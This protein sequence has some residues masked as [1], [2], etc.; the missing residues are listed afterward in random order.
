ME[1]GK[2][3]KNATLKATKSGSKVE[4]AYNYNPEI[5]NLLKEKFSG[6][7]DGKKKMWYIPA[8]EF[9]RFRAYIS[10]E[11]GHVLEEE[12]VAKKF[13]VK[14]VEKGAS[15]QYV[16]IVCPYNK[17]ICDLIRKQDGYFD[18]WDGRWSLPIKNLP[19]LLEC[20]SSDERYEVEYDGFADH[21][22]ENPVN[23]IELIPHYYSGGQVYIRYRYNK[24]VT[25]LLKDLF[26]AKFDPVEK[27]WY[28]SGEEYENLVRYCRRGEY[29]LADKDN[30]TLY[31]VDEYFYYT[32]SDTW[33]EEVEIKGDHTRKD[34]LQALKKYAP[35]KAYYL[36]VAAKETDDKACVQRFVRHCLEDDPCISN[37]IDFA[38]DQEGRIKSIEIAT[39]FTF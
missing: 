5:N 20:F 25:G 11:S 30:R 39:K 37:W 13:Q 24:E 14:I 27:C 3:E 10:K 33:Y 16:N 17:E 19:S 26:R 23:G 29:Y 6:R 1:M 28:V 38:Y 8:S 21:L 2:N 34:L 15:K 32:C 31:K 9:P 12:S 18:D 4:L 35:D 22:I 36:K 7:F